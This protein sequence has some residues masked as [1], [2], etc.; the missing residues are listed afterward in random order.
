METPELPKNLTPEEIEHQKQNLEQEPAKEDP[1][2]KDTTLRLSEINEDITKKE[3]SMT[4][5]QNQIDGVRD[6]LKLPPSDEVPPS[7]KRDQD[8]IEKLKQEKLQVKELMK[9]EIINLANEIIA[10]KETFPFSV[11]N[12]M[13]PEVYGRLKESEAPYVEQGYVTPI[14]TVIAK[15]QLEGITISLGKNPDKGE[16]YVFPALYAN[17]TE[18]SIFLHQLQLSSI[19]NPKLAE[20]VEKSIAYNNSNLPVL[21]K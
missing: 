16:V 6:Q 17:V 7:I 3:T 1:V 5:T 21:D 11:S 12:G 18:D 13:N 10:S 4:D 15:M 19:T 14:D 8:F 20:L 2:E 9:N